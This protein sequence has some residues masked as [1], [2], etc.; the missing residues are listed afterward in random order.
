[1]N[2]TQ[3]QEYLLREECRVRSM[4]STLSI[5]F[6]PNAFIPNIDVIRHQEPQI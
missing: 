1:M 4:L 6:S 5:R 3:L 2:I